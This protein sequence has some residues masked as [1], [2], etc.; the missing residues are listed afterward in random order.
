MLCPTPFFGAW[1]WW[2]SRK[3]TNS[4]PLTGTP[5]WQT[6]TPKWQTFTEQLLITQTRTY[7]E[8][9][10]M[11]EGNDTQ[12]I[13]RSKILYI[14]NPKDTTRKLLDSVN[15]VKCQDTGL[16]RWFNGNKLACQWKRCRFT[17]WVGNIPHASGPQL[18]SL[19]S[20]AREPQLLSPCTPEPSL[21][22]KR[23]HRNE[24]PTHHNCRV[25][26][27]SQLEKK[28]GQQ[29]RPSTTNILQNNN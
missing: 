4:C 21:R 17:P 11:T 12:A 16:P 26:P 29:W 1:P 24:K 18:L 20:R 14:E 13:H 15:L 28:P 10:S 27:S 8:R 19:C 2:W 6:F 7:Q 25:A 23:S 5:K 9:C 22:N 3:T